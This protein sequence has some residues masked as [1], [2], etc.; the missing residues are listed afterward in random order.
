MARSPNYPA[1]GLSEAVALARQLWEK[2]ER[3]PV[4]EE[5]AVEALGYSSLSGASRT[6]L[7]ALKKYDLVEDT[8]HG[9]R[10]TKRAV[11]ILHSPKD[12]KDYKEAVHK[13]AL[14]P[15]IFQQL[16][17][18][19]ASASESALRSHLITKMDFSDTGAKKCARSFRDTV[20]FANLDGPGYTEDE[21]LE[22]PESEERPAV[23]TVAQKPETDQAKVVRFSWPLSRDVS[24]EVTFTGSDVRPSHIENLRKYLDTVKSVIGDSGNGDTEG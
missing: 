15:E 1:V 23:A 17:E 13:A 9:V 7:S 2:E 24:V 14:S 11:D 19:Y 18:H 21:T 3:T 12:S 6:R 10:L 4:T 22:E 20:E 8:P 16:I 5:S